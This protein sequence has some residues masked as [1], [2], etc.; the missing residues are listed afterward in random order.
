MSLGE[1]LQHGIETETSII[2]VSLRTYKVM[3]YKE[4]ALR[5]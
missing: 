5:A 2:R 1:G 3:K 4:R